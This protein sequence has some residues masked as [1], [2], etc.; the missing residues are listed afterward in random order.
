[1]SQRLRGLRIQSD[2]ASA[3][4]ASTGRRE[5]DSNDD[6]STIRPERPSN[7]VELDLEIRQTAHFGFSFEQ[8]LQNSRVY[9]RVPAENP[10]S[11]LSSSVR[12]SIGWSLLSDLSL[13]EISCLSV[14][15]LPIS[16]EEIWN[17]SYYN[18][19]KGQTNHLTIPLVGK[20]PVNKRSTGLPFRSLKELS[21]ALQ[22]CEG[23]NTVLLMPILLPSA[24]ISCI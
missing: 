9:Q 7:G 15:S 19:G 4:F 24:T 10:K 20:T 22:Q 6:T 2:I 21:D 14:I 17:S 3:T 8:D 11:S 12:R 18:P 13:T 16:G 1:M 23:R 5:N